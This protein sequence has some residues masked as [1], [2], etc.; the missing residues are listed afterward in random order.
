VDGEMFGVREWSW[1]LSMIITE[2]E[3]M[4]FENWGVVFA[5]GRI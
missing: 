1:W 5:R 4:P 3:Q 2:R